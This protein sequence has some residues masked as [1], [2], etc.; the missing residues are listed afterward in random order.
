MS[1]MINICGVR[2]GVATGGQCCATFGVLLPY[3]NALNQKVTSCKLGQWPQWGETTCHLNPSREQRRWRRVWK[4][5]GVKLR[6]SD[7]AAAAPSFTWNGVPFSFFQ[8]ETIQK[9][10]RG[11]E[12]LG[13]AIRF[14]QMLWRHVDVN[15]RETA[16]HS[17]RVLRLVGVITLTMGLRLHNGAIRHTSVGLFYLAV[18]VCGSPSLLLQVQFFVFLVGILQ[19][20][21]R[22]GSPVLWLTRSACLNIPHDTA[23]K[24]QLMTITLLT[25]PL[26]I[27]PVNQFCALTTAAPPR[28]VKSMVIR[29]QMRQVPWLAET[30]HII[31]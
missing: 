29:P 31:H 4:R 7:A 20:W 22:L 8:M 5:G 28:D 6:R 30:L 25:Y 16:F 21:T 12:M 15:S 14:Y 2:V 19:F 27:V 26:S 24:V 11:K 10:Q 9:R 18:I 17:L 3:R 13:G 23:T 1:S